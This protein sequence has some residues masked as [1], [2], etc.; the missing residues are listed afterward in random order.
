MDRA[1]KSK[2]GRLPWKTRNKINEM[3]R[4]GRRYADVLEWVNSTIKPPDVKI[5]LSNLSDWRKT[6]YKLW[7]DE[8]KK[9]EV[10][11]DLADK[12]YFIADATGGNPAAVAARL[13]TEQLLKTVAALSEKGGAD[14]ELLSSLTK[15]ISLLN[16]S[17]SEARKLDLQK[18]RL[19]VKEEELRLNKA[20]FKTQLAEKFLQWVQNQSLVEVAKGG[21]SRED[22]IAAILRH[23]DAEER[24]NGEEV[25]A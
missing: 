2:I 4:D 6:G 12:S 9:N 25:G 13:I 15:A 20:R 19:D 1:S 21:A 3:L 22:K 10:L 16:T 24:D 14:P 11:R 7:G 5:T 8:R 17:E 23:M 18:Q